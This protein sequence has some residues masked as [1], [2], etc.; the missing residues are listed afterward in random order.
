MSGISLKQKII[1]MV[2]GV[3]VS[4][5]I[6]EGGLRL[7]GRIYLAWQ[8]YQNSR[9]FNREDKVEYRILCLGEST[10]AFGGENSYPRQLEEILN[11]KVKKRKFVVINKGMPD[12]DTGF[13]LFEL[14]RNLNRYFPHMVVTMMGIND[15]VNRLKPKAG[16]GDFIKTFRVYKA[17]KLVWI[18]LKPGKGLKKAYFESGKYHLERRHYHE[19][20]ELFKKAMRIKPK[21]AADYIWLGKC[22]YEQG[23]TVKA[24]E[25]FREAEGMRLTDVQDYV[26]AGWGYFDIGRAAKA[27]DMFQEV[28]KLKPDDYGSYVEIAQFYHDAGFSQKAE[29]MYERALELAGPHGKD[30]WPYSAFGWHYFELNRFEEAERMFRR[31]LEL[32]SQDPEIHLDL[33]YVKQAQGDKGQAEWHFSKSGSGD[34]RLKAFTSGNYSRIKNIV[35]KR[36][37]RLVCVQYPGRRLED[38][39]R[40]LDSP[41]GVVFVDNERV[42]KDALKEG[43]YE[44]YFTDRFAWDFGHCTPRGNNV[45]ANNIAQAIIKEY[46]SDR[47]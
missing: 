3:L 41:D 47:Q 2:L 20:Q 30:S 22:Y 13:I 4:V 40:M 44:D 33:A 15:S 12:T 38:L 8:D 9:A 27:E 32:N 23:Q 43:R 36:G 6:L 31:A 21:D 39:K 11:R 42:F 26:D 1:L 34:A 18:R 45:L 24:D 25:M 19:A 14:G 29:Q 46:F 37:I 28:I 7:A 17:L 16:P 5:T 10:T 35:L